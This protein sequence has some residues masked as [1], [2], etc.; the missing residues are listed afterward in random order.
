M[1][2]RAPVSGRRTILTA[3]TEAESARLREL[4]AG[5]RVLEVGSQYGYST[6]LMAAVA[7]SVHAVDWHRGDAIVGHRPSLP[8]LWANLA[9]F[10]VMDKVILHVGATEAVLPYLREGSFGFAFHDAFHSTEAVRA[11]VALLLPLLEPGALLAFHDY[12]R[13]GVAEAVDGLGLERVSL[14]ESLVVMQA[15]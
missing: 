11:D 12:G 8:E 14:T 9:A 13:Y 1:R 5:K 3:I 10:R 4:A 7:E 2:P 15:A 6:V